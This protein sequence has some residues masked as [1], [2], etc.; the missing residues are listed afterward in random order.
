M[1]EP[2]F[3]FCCK[4]AKSRNDSLHDDEAVAGRNRIF[5]SRDNEQFILRQHTLPFNVAKRFHSVGQ[6]RNFQ[7]D[8]KP[9]FIAI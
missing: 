8:W 3:L 4:C 2:C 5:V 6:F 7:P 9:W 1:R